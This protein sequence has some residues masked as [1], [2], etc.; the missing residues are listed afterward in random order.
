MKGLKIAFLVMLPAVLVLYLARCEN[1][2]G[3]D[4]QELLDAIKDIV[5][6]DSVVMLDGFDDGGAADVDYEQGFAKAVSDTFPLDFF[7]V[8]FGRRITEKPKRDVVVEIS[9]DTAIAEITSTIHGKFI[10]HYI[11][12]TNHVLK[13]SVVKDFTTVTK[14]RIKLYKHRNTRN[15]GRNWK[16]VAFTPI[17]GR[18]EGSDLEILSVSVDRN[19]EKIF[20]IENDS[21]DSIL[22]FYIDRDTFVNFRSNVLLHVEMTVANPT[23]FVYEPGEVALVHYGVRRGIMKARKRLTDPEND[24]VFEG[25]IRMHGH[26]SHMCRTF[27]DLIDMATIFDKSAPVNSTFW[28]LPYRVKRH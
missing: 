3:H 13:D 26:G 9:G 11:D 18:T 4:D 24:N 27:F 16:V 21:T 12:T 22:D 23:P 17:V 28:A 5:L 10:V 2:T 20:S 8:R 7:L 25:F 19:G 6:A 1:T 14:Q 15:P